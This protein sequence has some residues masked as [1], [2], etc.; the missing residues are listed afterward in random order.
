MDD[1]VATTADLDRQ[2]RLDLA[3]VFRLR[4]HYGW[5]D[6]I[7]NRAASPPYSSHSWDLETGMV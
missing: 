7:F 1:A 4:A 2:V 3:A 6:V 5:R